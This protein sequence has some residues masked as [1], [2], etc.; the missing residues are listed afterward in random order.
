MQFFER[1]TLIT[2]TTL[3]TA[4]IVTKDRSTVYALEHYHRR[5]NNNG[6]STGGADD[7]A[8]EPLSSEVA[9]LL[10]KTKGKD[11][12]GTCQAKTWVAQNKFNT[13][14]LDTTCDELEN[15]STKDRWNTGALLSCTNTKNTKVQPTA[16][17]SEQ[18]SYFAKEC[19]K[20]YGFT[21]IQSK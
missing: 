20:L 15:T 5:S 3:L 10:F 4:I 2:L 19:S 6:A 9:G 7:G 1:V 13:W 17:V 14:A 8:Y 18:N 16:S 12:V 21:W 11:N